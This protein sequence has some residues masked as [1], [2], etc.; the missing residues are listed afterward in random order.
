MAA[1]LRG[2]AAGFEAPGCPGLAA[3]ASAGFT[4]SRFGFFFGILAQ[5]KVN[6]GL[7][8]ISIGCF[9]RYWLWWWRRDLADHTG[10]ALGLGLHRIEVQDSTIHFLTLLWRRCCI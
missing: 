4:A 10:F 9:A 5:Q 6:K 7:T 2:A 8:Q 1:G 3:L